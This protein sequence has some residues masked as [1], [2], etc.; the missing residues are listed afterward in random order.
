MK[1]DYV[2]VDAMNLAY[3]S[4]WSCKDL[5]TSQGVHSGLEFGFMRATMNMV[6]NYNPAE[7]VFMFDGNPKRCL[8]IYPE[9]KKGRLKPQKNEPPWPPRINKIRDVLSKAFRCFYH[10]D[11]EADEQ[12]ARFVNNNQEKKILIVSNDK[13]ME[14][15]ISEN[16]HV[17]KKH[18]NT[19]M[20]LEDVEENWGVPSHKLAFY[21]AISGDVSDKIPGVKRIAT[22]SKV[23][24]A[25][26]SKSLENLLENIEKADYFKGKQ[27]E[28]ML[29]SRDLIQ[30]NYNLMNLR[31][32]SEEPTLLTPCLKDPEPLRDFMINLEFK[33][34]AYRNDWVELL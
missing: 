18:S 30:K 11:E 20:I 29:E 25:K 8:E 22:E 2:L 10:P 13:D 24:L 15:L 33:S 14:Q 5:K 31:G 4:W 1:Y 34:I 32:L 7:I 6:V 9:Y 17:A 28:K 21:R 16:C 26:E 23:K 12:I 3:R 19:P 27:K